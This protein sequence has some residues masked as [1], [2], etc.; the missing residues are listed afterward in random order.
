MV[1]RYHQ[2]N[3]YC[4]R[5]KLST[6]TFIAIFHCYM[7]GRT[8]SEAYAIISTSDLSETCS[9]QAVEGFYLKLGDYLWENFVFPKLAKIYEDYELSGE[10][11]S[12]AHLVAYYLDMMRKAIEAEIDYNFFREDGI[13]IGNMGTVK[14]LAERARA[15]KGLPAKTF[16]FHFAYVSFVDTMEEEVKKGRFSMDDVYIML[17]NELEKNPL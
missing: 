7:E 13:E 2:K 17:L 14:K 11:P 6:E 16:N 10:C 9:R 5:T 12:V 1:R 4:R 3:R 8:A 15:F